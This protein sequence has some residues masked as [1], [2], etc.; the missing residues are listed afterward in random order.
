M[1]RQG[2]DSDFLVRNLQKVADGLGLKYPEILA[3]SMMLSCDN[4]HSAHPNHPEKDDPTNHALMNKGIVIKYNANQSYTSDTLS[5]AIF[6]L[7][8]D[9]ANVQ[10]GRASCRERV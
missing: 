7:I 1:T 3:G 6:R 8:C 9:K 2:A 10:I 4:A 5:S